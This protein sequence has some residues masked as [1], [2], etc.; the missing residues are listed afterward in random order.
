MKIAKTK[1]TSSKNKI[2]YYFSYFSFNSCEDA[3]LGC[4]QNKKFFVSVRTKTNRNSICFGSVCLFRET[5]KIIFR[6]VSVFRNC[7]GTNRNKKSAFRNKLKRKINT[8]CEYARSGDMNIA[9][10]HTTF[11]RRIVLKKEW[12]EIEDFLL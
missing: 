7:F 5:K 10:V 6:L 12:S 4:P 2:C 9:M 8:L 3:R 1:K 11:F